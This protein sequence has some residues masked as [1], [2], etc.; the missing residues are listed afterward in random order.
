MHTQDISSVVPTSFPQS[1][2]NQQPRSPHFIRQPPTTNSRQR[3]RSTYH[4]HQQHSNFELRTLI[5]LRGA[6]KEK[7]YGRKKISGR[8]SYN[9]SDRSRSSSRSC[10]TYT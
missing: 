6:K 8:A 2:V 7:R 1:S 4:I 5:L 3:H 9:T 10:A